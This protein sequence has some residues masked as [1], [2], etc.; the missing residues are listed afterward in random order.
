MDTFAIVGMTTLCSVWVIVRTAANTVFL[1][2]K[3]NVGFTIFMLSKL[4]VDTVLPI[5][6]TASRYQNRVNIFL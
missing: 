2:Q 6:K 4:T 1:F 3:S 5:L